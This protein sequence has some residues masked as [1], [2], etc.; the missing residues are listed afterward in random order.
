MKEHPE[1]EGGAVTDEGP[2]GDDALIERIQTKPWRE[3]DLVGAH[4]VETTLPG[5]RAKDPS[6]RLLHV[7]LAWVTNGEIGDEYNVDLRSDMD[8]EVMNE[9]LG[10]IVGFS[11]G[12]IPIGWGAQS[13]A[14]LIDFLAHL[15]GFEDFRPPLCFLLRPASRWLD[16]S[17][18]VRVRTGKLLTLAD[19]LKAVGIVASHSRAI[20][21]AALAYALPA[22]DGFPVRPDWTASGT[23]AWQEGQ[24]AF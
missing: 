9:L 18:W 17:I 5:K 10:E 12:C 19:T 3:L 15:E 20:D 13:K 1:L 8:Y 21:V 23:C 16:P 7:H 22:R 24:E 14:F 11:R 2:V 6:I 4:V